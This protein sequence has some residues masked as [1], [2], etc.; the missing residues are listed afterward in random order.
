MSYNGWKNYETWCVALWLSNEPGTYYT[1]QDYVEFYKNEKH[2][3][4]KL[5]RFIQSYVEDA[6][7]EIAPSMYLDLLGYALEQVDYFEI[8]DSYLEE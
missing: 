5:A 1:I 6:M 7:P 2:L 8:A 4:A 3:E